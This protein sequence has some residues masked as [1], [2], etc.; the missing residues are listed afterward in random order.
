[1]CFDFYSLYRPP[2]LVLPYE[3]FS[4]LETEKIEFILVGDLNLKSKSI[5]RNIQDPSKDI[6]SDSR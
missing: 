6:G 1:M 4:K 3:F 5:G 2:S